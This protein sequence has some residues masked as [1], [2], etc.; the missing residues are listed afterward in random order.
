MN[1]TREESHQFAQQLEKIADFP[2]SSFDD[3]A[4]QLKTISSCRCKMDSINPNNLL[5]DYDN[6]KINII[7]FSDERSLFGNSRLDLINSL[8]DFTFY[9]G[10]R[11]HADR[12]DLK[13]IN[14]ASKKIIDKCT[15]AAEKYHIPLDSYLYEDYLTCVDSWFGMSGKN[16]HMQ[17]YK[18]M[19]KLFPELA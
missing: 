8:L 14:S 7:D 6:K 3:Y 15:I 18:A 5:I 1:V 4:R 17:R 9:R 12:D 10:Y 19:T 2:Q 13:I 11:K 16:S